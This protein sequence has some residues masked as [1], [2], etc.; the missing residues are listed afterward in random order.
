M[1]QAAGAGGREIEFA[2]LR[3]GQPN[4]FVHVLRR[5]VAGDGQHF[6]HFRHQRD[7]LQILQRIVGDFFHAGAD[8]KRARA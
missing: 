3:F 1:R 5:N 4:Q 2:G 8:R 6:R 7:R